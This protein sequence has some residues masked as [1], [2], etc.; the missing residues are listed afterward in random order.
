M[1]TYL[2]KTEPTEYSFDQLRRDGDT[3]WTGVSNAAALGCLRSIKRGDEVLI[4]HTGSERAV[5]GLARVTKGAFED[6]DRPGQTDDGHPKFAVVQLKALKPAAT[7][8]ELAS[9]KADARFKNFALVRISRLSVM[10]VPD[11]LD[12]I[13]RGLCGW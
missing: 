11:E 9:I 7:P 12:G 6:P 1:A 5:V 13:I 2:F 3:T 4:Y 8:L 10:P